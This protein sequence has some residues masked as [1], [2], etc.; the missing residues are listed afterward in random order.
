MKNENVKKLVIMGMMAALAYVAML[1]I[2]IPVVAFLKYEPKDVIITIAGFIFGPLAAFLISLVVSLV[3][4]VTVSDTGWIGALMN[5]ISTCAFA[6][7]AAIIYKKI[8]TIRGAVIGLLSGVLVMIAVM[9]LWNYLI[10]PI[11]MTMPREEVAK[12]LP[13]VF[14][15]FNA[16]KGGLNAAIT[17]LLYKP[18]VLTLRRANLIPASTG[19]GQEKHKVNVGLLVFAA[20]VLVTCI[21]FVLVLSGKI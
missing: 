16:L 17:M 13:T 21:I 15:P 19:S 9:M 2:R 10:T 20:A 1:L 3:E 8:H 14:L 11:Y 4:M 5:L 18:V 7:T 6:C 12:L